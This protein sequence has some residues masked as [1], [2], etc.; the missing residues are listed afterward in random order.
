[1]KNLA[2]LIA[3][4]SLGIMSCADDELGTFETDD[5]IAEP[6]DL[7]SNN[8]ITEIAALPSNV[9]F[10]VD[11]RYSEAKSELGRL[12]FWDPILSGNMD[13]SCASCHHPDF[14]YADGIERSRGVGAIGLGNTRRGG[15]LIDRNAPT[16]INTG[17]NGIEMTTNYD[18]SDAPMFWD[19]RSSG[20]EEQAIE[21]ILSAVEMRGN[22]IAEDEILE[23]II[24]RLMNISEYQSLF[25]EAFGTSVITSARIAQ[26]LSTFQRSIISNNSRF[27]QYMR[28]NDN[29]LTQ[30]ELNGLQ[31]F[32]NVG[33]ADCHNGA[34]LSD[35]ELHTLSVPN[36]GINDAGIN[37]DY[38]FRTP[39]LRNVELTA[40]YMHNGAFDD[41]DDVLDFYDDISGGRNRSRNPNVNDNQIADDARNLNLNNNQINNIIAFLGTLTDEN[42]DSEIPESV[43][44]NLQSGGNID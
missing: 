24:Q 13:V 21:P 40:P 4:C 41:L 19:N 34:M 10:P 14:G 1:M 11:N 17:F 2:L 16:I 18:P 28:G 29:V 38:A 3:I 15:T 5:P 35:Y 6:I 30:Q 26:A 12:L 23:V 27:D 7:T 31:A 22:N 44:S 33:C 25:D 32:I 39:S 42:F 9:N 37:G 36:N 8:G 43:P 20:L